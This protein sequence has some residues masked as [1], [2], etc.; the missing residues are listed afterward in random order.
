MQN[1]FTKSG[2]SLQHTMQTEKLSER[3]VAPHQLFFT[4]LGVCVWEQPIIEYH[5]TEIRMRCFPNL[6]PKIN[7][8]STRYTAYGK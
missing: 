2:V 6:L 3:Y 4:K 8:G 5:T 1:D 7:N